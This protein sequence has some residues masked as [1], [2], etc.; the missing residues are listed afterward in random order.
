MKKA[1][2]EAFSDGVFAIVITLLILDIKLPKV[3]YNDLPAAL[4]IILPNISVYVLSFLIIGMYWVFHHY[5]F[6]F[7]KE[8][9]GVLLW[10]N[11]LVLLF[12]SFLPFPTSLMGQYPYQTIP[13]VMYGLNLLCA[14]AVGF[15]SLLYL[16]KNKQLTTEMFTP[17]LFRSQM[18]TYISVNVMYMICIGLAFFMPKFSSFLFG[19]I[20]VYLIIRSVIF[21][22]IGNCNLTS[23]K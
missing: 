6:M 12:I 18:H 21:M 5:T 11:I 7:M 19:I 22:G 13:I 10:L 17:K 4:Y 2:L 8:A 15:I 3:D 1:R 9:D 16:N 20:S 23:R 14:N